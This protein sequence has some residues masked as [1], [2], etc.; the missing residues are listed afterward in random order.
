[1]I[2]EGIADSLSFTR[3][4]MMIAEHVRTRLARQLCAQ[5][6]AMAGYLPL[7]SL[8]AKWEQHFAEAM[9]GQGDE[10]HLA[11]QPSRVSEFITLVREKFEEA[12]RAGEAPVLV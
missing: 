6:S 2:L 5:Y 11:M 9:I 12:A 1:T 8:S 3:N 10:R 4:P 7:I